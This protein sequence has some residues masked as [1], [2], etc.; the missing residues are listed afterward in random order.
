MGQSAYGAESVFEYAG[1]GE[2][3]YIDGELTEA[4]FNQPYGICVDNQGNLLVA[5][6]YNNCIRKIS[7]T[8]VSTI[9]GTSK[10]TDLMGFLLGGYLDGT[11]STAYFN[12]PRDVLMNENGELFVADTGNNVIRKVSNGNVTTLAGKETAGYQDGTGTRALFNGPAGMAMNEDGLLYVA[13]TKNNAIRVISKDGNVSTMKFISSD[14]SFDY[15]K[16]NEPSDLAFGPDQTLYILDSG[17]QMIKKV[18]DGVIS[19]VAGGIGVLDEYGYRASGFQD[20]DAASATFNFPK[21]I[22]V[23]DNG[24]I[25]VA[26]T[27][28]HSIRMVK[29]DGTVVTLSGNGKAGNQV[30]LVGSNEYNAPSGLAYQN[31]SLYVSDMWNNEIKRIPMNYGDSVFDLSLAYATSNV[32][33]S[34]KYP[35]IVNVVVDNEFVDFQDVTTVNI[36]GKT[37]F[38]IRRIAESMGATVSY[39]SRTRVI[40]IAYQGKTVS[41][42]LNAENIKVINGRSLI[43]IRELATDLGFFLTW[44]GTNQTVIVTK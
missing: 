15:S 24:L 11:V 35:G 4:A 41:Y 13:D 31:G 23:L 3:N 19:K 1:Q 9:A 6:T 44:D 5:D 26:D 16:L 27:W 18:I 20:G 34:K 8:E 29:K 7:G 43:H 33:Y 38:P 32:D 10:T 40:T 22:C 25:L 37:Y 21:G 30:G 12:K 36:G 14:A 42:S 2:P 28:N 17:N 39:D